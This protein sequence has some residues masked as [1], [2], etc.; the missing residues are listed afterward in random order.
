[1]VLLLLLRLRWSLRGFILLSGDSE[2]WEESAE[3]SVGWRV[4]RQEEQIC[5]HRCADMVY[6]GAMAVCLYVCVCV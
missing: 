1:M 5:L 4:C 3:P 6:V 2:R